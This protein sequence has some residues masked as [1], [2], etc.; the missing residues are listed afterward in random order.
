MKTYLLLLLIVLGCSNSPT[1]VDSERA[2]TYR[3]VAWY[4]NNGAIVSTDS[5]ATVTLYQTHATCSPL[6]EVTNLF[7]AY[8]PETGGAVYY[9]HVVNSGGSAGAFVAVVPNNISTITA[10]C[11][12]SQ[13]GS[14][15]QTYHFAGS[16]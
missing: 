2:T 4:T 9:G 15:T 6:G 11:N 7:S 8:D 16:R 3:G 13:S 1:S 10:T 12:I 14:V 5:T